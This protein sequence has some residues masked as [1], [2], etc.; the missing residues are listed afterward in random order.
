MFDIE[1]NESSD[2]NA[3]QIESDEIESD[4]DYLIWKPKKKCN[5]SY[6]G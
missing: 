3:L 4:D 6:L 2:H 5:N 1:N